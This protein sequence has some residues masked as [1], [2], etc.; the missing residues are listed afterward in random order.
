[1]KRNHVRIAAVV[2]AALGLTGWV[3]ANAGNLLSGR[4]TAVAVMD[5]QV[6]FDSLK[7][8]MQ[9]EA[10]LKS[11][12]E[13]INTDDQDRKQELQELRSDLD[14]LAPDTPAYNE[15]QSQLEQKAIELQAW[16]NFQTQKLN[17]E[18]GLQIE[19]LYR[20]MLTAAGQLCKQNGYDLVLFKEQAVNFAG[21]KPEAL[22]TLIQVRKVL[23]SADD[24][25][26]T[27]QVIQLMNNEFTNSTE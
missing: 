14:I 7:E 8:K 5:V 2:A 12:L 25:D 18:R 22:K 17:H 9:I 23:W 1:M 15:K 19:K 16:R 21:A 11:Q 26:I 10:D 6:I 4:P 27:D 20:K 3:A 13:Q 24:L